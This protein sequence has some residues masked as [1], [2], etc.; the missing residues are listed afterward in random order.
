V[1]TGPAM[2]AAFTQYTAEIEPGGVLGPTEAQRFLFVLEGKVQLEASGG[3][4]LLAKDGYA[5]LPAAEPSSVRAPEAARI[6]GIEKGYQPLSG[7]PSAA[8]TDGR[9]GGRPGIRKPDVL[10]GDE[11]S[12]APQ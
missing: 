8:R 4:H 5:Y 6:A 1:H 11:S 3:K 9:K 2:G 12:I 7:P 10:I